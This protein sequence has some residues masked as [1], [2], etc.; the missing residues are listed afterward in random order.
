M[1]TINERFELDFKGLT[2]ITFQHVD[3][4]IEGKLCIKNTNKDTT[5]YLQVYGSSLRRE[6]YTL[7]VGKNLYCDRSRIATKKLITEMLID[8]HPNE[9][10]FIDSI[11]TLHQCHKEGYQYK[12]TDI[13]LS[14]GY[15]LQ[16]IV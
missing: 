1:K 8:P 2:V 3:L 4:G 15:S 10:K 16:V 14:T 13:L 6:I 11:S 12:L 9:Q 5:V 7:H